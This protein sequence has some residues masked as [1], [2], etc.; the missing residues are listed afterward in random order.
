MAKQLNPEMFVTAAF[1]PK[2]YSAELKKLMPASFPIGM[3]KL[4]GAQLPDVVDDPHRGISW[5]R[6]AKWH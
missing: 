2:R 1:P 3:A 5:K 4:R 6:P